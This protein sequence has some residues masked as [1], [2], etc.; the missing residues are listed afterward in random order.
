MAVAVRSEFEA[1]L[2]RCS[3]L[4]EDVTYPSVKRW[5]EEH[6][7]GHAVGHF[8]VYFPEE[9]IHAAGEPGVRAR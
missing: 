4:A 1:I 7:D 9:L 8:Q 5:R 3:G 2:E 6:P